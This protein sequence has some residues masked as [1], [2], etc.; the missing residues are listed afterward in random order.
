MHV[1]RSESRGGDSP[2]TPLV[3]FARI[4]VRKILSERGIIQGQGVLVSQSDSGMLDPDGKGLGKDH[5]RI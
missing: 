4:A 2:T 3:R 1:A 5:T